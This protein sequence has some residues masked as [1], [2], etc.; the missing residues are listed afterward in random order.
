MSSDLQARYEVI[1]GEAIERYQR[2]AVLENHGIFYTLLGWQFLATYVLTFAC[3]QLW[4]VQSRWIY[5]AI[6]IAQFSIAVA[7][8]FAI[9][10]RGAGERSPLE[11]T[12][13]GLWLVFIA[14]CVFI[15]LLNI[16][17]DN[18]L[19]TFLPTFAALTVFAFAVMTRLFSRKFMLAGNFM[20]PVGILMV[21]FP[22][23]ALLLYGGA[24]FVILQGLGLWFWRD[25]RRWL[26]PTEMQVLRSHET[27]APRQPAE[28]NK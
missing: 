27:A 18:R 23:Y 21:V 7:T 13:K 22:Q 8:Y 4:E 19:F 1:R 11:R 25:R 2:S 9:V 26:G 20:V 6:K 12:N 5:L 14:V 10:G 16:I 3:H 24:W 17:A 15:D 28:A